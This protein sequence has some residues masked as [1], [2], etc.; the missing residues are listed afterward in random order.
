[1]VKILLVFP[2]IIVSVYKRL[3]KIYLK[4]VCLSINFKIT[5]KLR[6]DK[7]KNELFFVHMFF[8][9]LPSYNTS[10][11]YNYDFLA[12]YNVVVAHLGFYF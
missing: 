12:F 8:S 5:N 2:R 4:K 7:K 10:N 11:C 9:I 1:M 6:F 3:L